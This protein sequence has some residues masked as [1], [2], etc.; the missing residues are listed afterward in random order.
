MT[1]EDCVRLLSKIRVLA[2]LEVPS[3]DCERITEIRGFLEGVR[4]A[5][6]LVEGLDPLYHVWEAE[7]RLR[8]P[9]ERGYEQVSVEGLGVETRDGYVRL[10]WRGRL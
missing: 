3:D 8:D 10:P 9:H 6:P 5:G 4:R 2:R 7:S 1:G